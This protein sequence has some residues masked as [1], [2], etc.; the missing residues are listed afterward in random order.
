MDKPQKRRHRSTAEPEPAPAAASPD[1]ARAAP[2]GGTAR[3]YG[4]TSPQGSPSAPGGGD[5]VATVLVAPEPPPTVPAGEPDDPTPGPRRRRRLAVGLA[6]LLVASAAGVGGWWYTRPS[7]P[8]FPAAWDPRV[9]DLVSFVEDERGLDFEH[10]VH[11]DFVADAEFR[12]L[13]TSDEADLTAEDREEIEEGVGLLRAL[14]LVEGDIDLFE[15]VNKLS[16]EGILAFYDPETKRIRV[17]GTEL[18]VKVRGT[19]VHELTHALQDQVFDLTRE[20]EF[21]IEAQNDTY[22]PV[23]EGDA[24]RVETAWV[25]E[26]GEADLAA[27]SEEVS[28]EVEGTDLSDIP[29]ALQVFFFSDYDFGEPFVQALLADGGRKAVDRALEEPPTSDA[30]LLDPFRYLAGDRPEDVDEPA[31]AAGEKRSDGGDFGAF[32][33]YVVLAQRI[34]PHQALRAADAWEGDAYVTYRADGRQCVQAAFVA[35]DAAGVAALGD[36]LGAWVS[37]MPDGVASLDRRADSV[38]LT[39]CDPGT[40]VGDAA[41]GTLSTALALP[42]TRTYMAL[43]AL[44]GGLTRDLAYC[45]GDRF[46]AGFSA[47]EL[48]SMLSGTEATDALVSGAER[49]AVACRDAG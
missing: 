41:P 19:L 23:F 21:E 26:L 40:D 4:Y 29:E 1:P 31:L 39:S 18:T 27:Y 47:A 42:L 22:R 28:A 17:R 46:I 8:S 43:G 25:E 32:G 5:A 24:S 13:V 48:Q 35:A 9:A 30:Q 45:V 11:V 10:P 38:R 16:G 20:G 2:A 33:L 36:A 3:R 49:A 12:E 7:G 6:V 14:G 15:A 44:G 34:D 37:A